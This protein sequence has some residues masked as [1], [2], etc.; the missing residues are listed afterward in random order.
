V[1]G[2]ALAALTGAPAPDE[3]LRR[4]QGAW[5]RRTV[6]VY[7]SF[8]LPCADTDLAAGC[9]IGDGVRFTVRMADGRTYAQSV[10]IADAPTKVLMRGGFIFGPGGA[11]LGFYRRV[12]AAAPPAPPPNLAPDPLLETIATVSAVAHTY[13][14]V[15]AGQDIIDGR[16][17]YHLVL[18]TGLDRDKFPL[19]DV[20]VDEESFEIRALTYDWNFDDGHRGDVHYVFASVGPQT[21]WAIVHIDAQVAAVRELFHTRIDRAADD[22]ADI[23]FPTT[24]PDDDFAPP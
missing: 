22:L 9:E 5:Q 18:R 17:C 16:K 13:D 15:L 19:R 2:I 20:W 4:A 10:P 12:G 6:P 11:P 24:E 23:E 7:E 1:L 3:I 21:L 8:T 14:I